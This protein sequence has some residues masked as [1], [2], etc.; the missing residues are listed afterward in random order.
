MSTDNVFRTKVKPVKPVPLP[1]GKDQA[2]SNVTDVEVPHLDYSKTKGNPYT[3]DYFELGDTWKDPVGGFSK[4]VE[5]IEKYFNNLI[6]T[7]QV[8][9]KTSSIKEKLKE[10]E[11]LTNTKKEDRTVVKIAK[12]SAY[13]KFLNEASEIESNARKYTLT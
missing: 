7:G 11:K 6:E 1:E 4:E 13:V 10:L 9:N 5:Q 12:I 2:M 3:V 8:A